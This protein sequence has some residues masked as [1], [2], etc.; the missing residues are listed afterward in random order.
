MKD[1]DFNEWKNDSKL[2]SNNLKDPKSFEDFTHSEFCEVVEELVNRV[3]ELTEVALQSAEAMKAIGDLT[4][5]TSE[6]QKDLKKYVDQ[7]LETNSKFAKVVGGLQ[8]Q[9]KKLLKIQSEG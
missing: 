5:A 1:I 4:T 6:D 9:F 3:N 2:H 8:E 7:V